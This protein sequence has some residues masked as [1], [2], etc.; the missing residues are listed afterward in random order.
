[1]EAAATWAARVRRSENEP[2]GA[3]GRWGI[4]RLDGGKR[5]VAVQRCGVV[6]GGL[7]APQAGARGRVPGAWQGPEQELELELVGSCSRASSGEDP[8]RGRDSHARRMVW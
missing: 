1:M 3:G 2:I 6:E 5:P 4:P 7:F 8:R